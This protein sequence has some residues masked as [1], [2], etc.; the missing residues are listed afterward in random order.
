VVELVRVLDGNCV[1]HGGCLFR[2]ARVVAV[3]IGDVVTCSCNNKNNNNVVR[4]NNNN[5]LVSDHLQNSHLSSLTLLTHLSLTD[6]ANI[7]DN[8]LH[9]MVHLQSL[10]VCGMSH[11]TGSCFLFC[12]ASISSLSL[13]RNHSV[14]G[15]NLQHLTN[16]QKLNL[17]LNKSIVASDLGP[18]RDKITHLDLSENNLVE[19]SVLRSMTRLEWL[20][21]WSNELVND[22]DL[23]CLERLQYLSLRSNG[24]FDVFCCCFVL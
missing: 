21:L 15:A 7:D 13:F 12:G 2:Q 22:D 10:E 11:I 1:L 19:G 9:D 8:A 16:L 14:C 3:G 5:D 20:S 23:V 24:K 17:H 4:N 6:C 18:L